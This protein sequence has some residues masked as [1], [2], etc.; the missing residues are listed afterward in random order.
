MTR[1]TAQGHEY[2]SIAY[3]GLTRTEKKVVRRAAKQVVRY[4]RWAKALKVRLGA[5]RKLGHRRRAIDA[6]SKEPADPSREW[7]SARTQA[8]KDARPGTHA[9]RR[10]PPFPEDTGEESVDRFIGGR[11]DAY[12]AE[13]ASVALTVARDTTF[14]GRCGELAVGGA[15]K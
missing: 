9:D 8:K 14:R 12:W 13:L 10:N 5:A 3:T 4:E 15:T 1:P 6:Y 11:D 7:V 2:G